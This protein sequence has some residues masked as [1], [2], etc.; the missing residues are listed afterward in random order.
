MI[1]GS[2][3]I[4]M[5]CGDAT[6]VT[7]PCSAMAVFNAAMSV[8]ATLADVVPVAGRGRVALR[9]AAALQSIERAAPPGNVTSNTCASILT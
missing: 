1:A 4:A 6:V 2:L 9:I 5:T 8:E 7:A 3:F